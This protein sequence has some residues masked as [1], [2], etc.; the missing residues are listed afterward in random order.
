MYLKRH[1][2]SLR[3]GWG[4]SEEV[5][6]R[7]SWWWWWWCISGVSSMAVLRNGSRLE[8]CKWWC[9]RMQWRTQK[10]FAEG[11]DEVFNHI[12]KGCGRVFCLKYTLFFFSRSVAARP[13]ARS[14]HVRM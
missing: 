5:V 6:V 10:F 14:A 2:Q 12:F 11:A 9:V 8:C 3:G 13:K 1:R 4:V 7:R